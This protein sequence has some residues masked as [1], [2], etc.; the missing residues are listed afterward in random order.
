[1]NELRKQES[2]VFTIADDEP[3][4]AIPFDKDGKEEVLYA[5]NEDAADRALGL[6]KQRERINLAGAWSHLDWDDAE[7]YL[8]RIDNESIPPPPITDIL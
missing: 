1:M 8:E 4:F 7:A 5:T 2:G 6:D 3:L